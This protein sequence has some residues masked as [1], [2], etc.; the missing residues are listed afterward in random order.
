MT[1]VLAK[2]S[3]MSSRDRPFVSLHWKGG[4]GSAI[5]LK[6]RW[7][8]S[9]QGERT[10]RSSRQRARWCRR[11]SQRPCSTYREKVES[12]KMIAEKVQELRVPPTNLLERDRRHLRNHEV[13][14][15][16][17]R[18][19]DGRALGADRRVHDLDG[20]SPRDGTDGGR[21]GKV[22]LKGAGKRSEVS[23]LLPLSQERVR[24]TI[25]VIMTKAYEAEVLPASAG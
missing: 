18:R 16:R 11:R 10:G 23:V 15:P 8:A 1:Y 20:V 3:S 12:A 6:R 7:A 17:R 9:D 14:D 4:N 5:M 13:G 24:L 2:K 21:E 19:G 22:E 25:Q